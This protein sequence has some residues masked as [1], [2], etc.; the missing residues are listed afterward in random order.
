MT[1]PAPE[2]RLFATAPDGTRLPV[3]DLTDSAFAVP[4]TDAELEALAA[5]AL[6]AEEKRGPIQR[7][8]I[9]LVLKLV[10]RN[11]RVIAALQA[12]SKGYLTGIATYVMK[13]GPDN[14][15]PPFDTDID[16]A[17]LRAPV[18]T[19]MRIRLEQV[20]TLLAEALAPLLA[21][22]PTAP[23]HLLEIAGGPSADGLNALLFLEQKGLLA[24]RQVTVDIYDLDG[25][26]PAF[27]AAMLEA[28]KAGK[29][30]GRE[31]V[32]RHITG[33]WSDAARLAEAV[34][35]I[36]AGAVVAATSE[37]GLFEYGSDADITGALRVLALRVDIVTG[38]V[39]RNDRLNRLM[40]LHSQAPTVARGL[41]RF[42]ELIAPT[43]YRIARSR[44]CPLS[45]QV[46]LTRS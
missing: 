42:A 24:G 27:A 30:A 37:G 21:A 18:V 29:L 6:A 13:L 33:N 46:L 1:E 39:T 41:E 2:S 35:A 16:K 40:K 36:P 44:P 4:E 28:L 38:S 7:F 19:S 45:D 14:L 15:V 3:I 43:G 32:C 25:D 9:G 17:V 34:A 23:L 11:S 22:D 12:A 20:A 5:S 31:I 10:A 26:G 8:L